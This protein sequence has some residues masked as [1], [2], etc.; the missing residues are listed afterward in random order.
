MSRFTDAELWRL[1]QIK[2]SVPCPSC[3]ASTDEP[4]LTSAG[5]PTTHMSRKRAALA[6]PVPDPKEN[7]VRE[8][9]RLRAMLA[10]QMEAAPTTPAAQQDCGRRARAALRAL[11]VPAPPTDEDKRTPR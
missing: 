11:A 6:A 10:Q 1:T 8:V 2:W 3:G 9:R 7:H 4:C 5:Y